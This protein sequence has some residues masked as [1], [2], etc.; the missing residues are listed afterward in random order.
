MAYSEIAKEMRQ[1]KGVNK[2][3]APCQAW[4]LWAAPDGMCKEHTSWAYADN[5]FPTPT[6][7]CAAYQ[8][9]HRPGG[10]L[11]RWPDVP[12]E[13]CSIPAGTHKPRERGRLVTEFSYDAS[14]DPIEKLDRLIE[15]IKEGKFR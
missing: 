11:C 14:K 10:G 2:D 9:P 6:C 7:R 4:A 3:G 13:V 1:C 12:A 5:K 8:W 15:L